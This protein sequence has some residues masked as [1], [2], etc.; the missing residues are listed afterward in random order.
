MNYPN[1]EVISS[2]YGS[3]HW[4]ITYLIDGISHD[5]SLLQPHFEANCIN[6]IVGHIIR[7]RSTA[8]HLLTAEPVFNDALIE[9]FKT[10]SLPVS[11]PDDA[12][13][14]EELVDKLNLSQERITAALANISPEALAAEKETDRGV[15]PVGEHLAGL[16]W[17]E[18]YHTG[19]LEPLRSLALQV[20]E[21]TS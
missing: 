1:A 5:E 15:K 16:A 17:H 10:G 20:R 3:N 4:L 8:L 7:G 14:F 2:T 18:T 11:G 21:S 12:I 19:Q 9:R 6:W 13:P